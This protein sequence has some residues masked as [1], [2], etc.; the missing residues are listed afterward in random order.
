VLHLV[1]PDVRYHETFMQA[2]FEFRDEFRNADGAWGAPACES[3]YPGI[4]FTRAEMNTPEGFARFVA[5]KLDDALEAAP[6]PR[7]QVPTTVLWI[8]DDATEE[9]LG[10][11]HIRHRLTDFLHD[12][13]GHV[14]YSVRP[15]A[16]GRGVA[17]AALQQSLGY[18]AQHLGMERVLITTTQLN[19]A[20]A[21]VIE[22]NGGVLEDVSRGMLRYWLATTADGQALP[23]APV[24]DEPVAA[25]LVAAGPVEAELVEAELVGDGPLE[26]G[27]VEAGLV[28]AEPVV[29]QP[30][31]AEPSPARTETSEPVFQAVLSRIG[32]SWS[33]SGR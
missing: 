4:S 17:S 7:V 23:P 9:F 12:M 13:G 11:V 5:W 1:R 26:A 2:H 14:S 32:L 25:E 8:I 6:R 16:R 3:G 18:A 24:A 22:H 31:G 30:V 21:R 10:S 33:R 27:L 29:A 20:S 15:S 28:E 19:K